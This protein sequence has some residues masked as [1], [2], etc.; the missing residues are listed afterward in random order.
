MGKTIQT[1][2]G[3]FFNFEDVS[4]FDYD[5]SEIAHALSK[6]CRFTGHSDEFYSV[7]Q[8]CV[9][10]SHFVPQEYALE[11]L[12][13]DASEAYLG[14]VSTHLKSLLPEYKVLEHEVEAAISLQ[15]DLAFPLPD[16]VKEA[17]MFM[18]AAEKTAFLGET[19]YDSE[20][21]QSVRDMREKYAGLDLY[22]RRLKA[23]EPIR[24]QREFI[25]RFLELAKERWK[26]DEDDGTEYT[27]A[28]LHA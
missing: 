2:N 3:K 6:I 26:N 15:Y 23:W 13:H 8:H 21:W 27:G 9:E 11:A 1:S 28:A 7:A 17:D 18:L 19:V 25:E 24:A 12:M 4:N 22:A 14:D 16:C 20:E 10:A 5:I